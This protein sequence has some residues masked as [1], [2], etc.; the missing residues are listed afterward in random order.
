MAALAPFVADL[1]GRLRARLLPEL[2]GLQRAA[3]VRR[4]ASDPKGYADRLTELLGQASYDFFAEWTPVRLKG[5]A[6]PFG[7]QTARHQK[8]EL[9]KQLEA[10]LGV[11]VVRAEPWLSDRLQAFATH[12]AS[13]ITGVGERALREVETLTLQGL[14]RGQRHEDLAEEIEQRMDV[15]ESRAQLIARDQ[16]GKLMGELNQARQQDLGIAGY[17]W[18]TVGDERVRDEHEALDGQSFDWDDPPSEGHPGEPINCRC[19]AEPDLTEL[20]ESL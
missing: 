2:P 4:D 17:V 8:R 1:R 16:V 5:I 7:E 6:L 19:S 11:D 20:L 3:G 18:R 9:Q 12:N 10:G 14:R 15:S 13:L